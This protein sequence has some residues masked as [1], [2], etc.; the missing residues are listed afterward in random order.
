MIIEFAP[1]GPH[2]IT[3]PSGNTPPSGNW[4]LKFN[5]SLLNIHV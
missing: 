1:T 5:D 2:S 3:D 4:N